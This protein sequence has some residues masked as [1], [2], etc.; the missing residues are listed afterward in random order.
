MNRLAADQLLDPLFGSAVIFRELQDGK[1][2][3][4]LGSVIAKG[5]FEHH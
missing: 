5:V 4:L 2:R 1:I 3:K